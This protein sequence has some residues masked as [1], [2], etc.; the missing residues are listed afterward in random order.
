M[1][2]GQTWRRSHHLGLHHHP[3]GSQ[4]S[5]RVVHIRDRSNSTDIFFALWSLV[6]V[7]L[8][9][10][11]D[12]G[13]EDEKTLMDAKQSR[14]MDRPDSANMFFLSHYFM[15]ANDGYKFTCVGEPALSGFSVKR[16]LAILRNRMGINGK[17]FWWSDDVVRSSMLFGFC[18]VDWKLGNISVLHS[19]PKV[20]NTLVYP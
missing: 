14:K 17:R 9:G 12:L 19:Q 20:E 5:S 1:D 13:E 3:A 18:I 11:Q 10:Q 2:S 15:E 16:L 4:W 8:D 6:C 7:G